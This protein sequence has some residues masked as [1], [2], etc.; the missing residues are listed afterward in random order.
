MNR[1]ADENRELELERAKELQ[2][3][4]FNNHVD[5][6][7]AALDGAIL[8][9]NNLKTKE[10]FCYWSNPMKETPEDY[11]L[12]LSQA[13]GIT[14][15][16]QLIYKDTFTTTIVMHVVYKPRCDNTLLPD[17]APKGGSS[18]RSWNVRTKFRQLR[19][20]CLKSNSEAGSKGNTKSSVI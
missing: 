17:V 7:K 3:K 20:W 8:G 18:Y 9:P 15:P 10:T 14:A 4:E 2:A 16:L 1:S 5:K 6:L 19:R 13:L 12:G 11:V